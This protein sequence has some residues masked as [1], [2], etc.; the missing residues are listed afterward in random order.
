MHDWCVSFYERGDGRLWRV[1]RGRRGR[2]QRFNSG[3]QCVI[4]NFN[5]YK[6]ELGTKKTEVWADACT[7]LRELMQASIGE[8]TRSIREKDT[9]KAR[10]ILE[11]CGF[12]EI[13]K[14]EFAD[15]K[16]TPVSF[17]DVLRERADKEARAKVVR[18]KSP[19]DAFF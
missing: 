19:L 7:S 13:I 1:R 3:Y 11:R 4:C 18:V 14:G 12:E 5:Q 15:M 10:W 9:A 16:A 17:D 2:I 6:S 8:V